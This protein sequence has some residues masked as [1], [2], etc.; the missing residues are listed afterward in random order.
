VVHTVVAVL[1][2]IWEQRI[3]R[4][5]VTQPVQR[6][7]MS[8]SARDFLKAVRALHDDAAWGD[9]PMEYRLNWIGRIAAILIEGSY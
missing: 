1:C 6:T 9:A 5:V 3:V 2:G 7:P 8:S 4:P